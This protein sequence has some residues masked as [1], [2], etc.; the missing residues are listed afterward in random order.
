M[1]V[2]HSFHFGPTDIKIKYKQHYFTDK[3]F[4]KNEVVRIQSS[5]TI[6]GKTKRKLFFLK[7]TK[8]RNCQELARA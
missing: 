4:I 5:L 6:S 8:K 1:K 3:Q 7:Q 2:L